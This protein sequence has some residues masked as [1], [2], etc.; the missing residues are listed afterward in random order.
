[1][2]TTTRQH[3]TDVFAVP[4]KSAELVRVDAVPATVDPPP[5]RQCFAR[6]VPHQ[7]TDDPVAQA[8]Q[9]LINEHS[10]HVCVCSPDRS[11]MLRTKAEMQAHPGYAD[12]KA[13]R[14]AVMHH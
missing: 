3:V 9:E 8:L 12:Y 1:M 11:E 5:A 4:V 2:T 10:H 6:A 13:R 14:D 7:E